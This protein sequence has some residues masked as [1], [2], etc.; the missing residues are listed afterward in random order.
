MG[1]TN[2]RLSLAVQ[3]AALRS[4]FPQSEIKGFMGQSISWN[5]ILKPTPLSASYRVLLKY[6][7]NKGLKFYVTDPK[8]LTL[9]PGEITLP[10]VYSTPEQR[11]CLYYP[12]GTEWNPMM[13]YTTTIIPWAVEW[14]AHYE[15]WVST[16]K[17][18]G[19]GTNHK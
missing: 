13:L 5:Y 4:M 10:H 7:I 3:H 1:K 8:P 16:G 12:D 9:A 17:W 6:S 18:H 14:L 2:N 19:G 11:L 15:I